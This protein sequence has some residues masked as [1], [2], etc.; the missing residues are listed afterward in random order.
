MLLGSMI[1]KLRYWVLFNLCSCRI[2]LYEC[3]FINLNGHEKHLSNGFC[4]SRDFRYYSCFRG[5]S[6][7]NKIKASGVNGMECNV[8]EGG[9]RVWHNAWHFISQYF[10]ECITFLNHKVPFTFIYFM[11]Q[12][13]LLFYTSALKLKSMETGKVRKKRYTILKQNYYSSVQSTPRLTPII[14]KMTLD[15]RHF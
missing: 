14:A 2:L 8:L 15:G 5:Q 12:Y 11:Y 6:Y 4:N 1:F 13:A 7:I 3:Y 9:G 10:L